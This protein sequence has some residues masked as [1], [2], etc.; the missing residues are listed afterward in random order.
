MSDDSEKGSTVFVTIYAGLR[1]WRLPGGLG[2][3]DQLDCRTDSTQLT[4]ST[5]LTGFS[6]IFTTRSL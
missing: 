4:K 3:R 2:R 6:R 5:R 1:D